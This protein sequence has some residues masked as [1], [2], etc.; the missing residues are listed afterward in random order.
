MKFSDIKF[1][2]I[3]LS[4]RITF[5]ALLLVVAGGLLWMNKDLENDREVYLSERSADLKMDIHLEQVRLTQSIDSLRQDVLFLA[6]LPSVSGIVRA[7]ANNGIDPRDKSTYAEWEVRL[8]EILA[9]FLRAHPE[10]YQASYIGAAGEGRELVQVENRDGH[11]VVAPHDALQ[12]RGDRDYFKAGLMLTAGRVYLSD[13]APDLEQGGTQELHRPALHAVTTVFDASGRVFGMVVINKDVHS[14]FASISEGLPSAVQSYMADQ[15]GH[16]LFHADAKS[17]EPGGKDN[18]AGDFPAL[19]PMFEPQTKHNDP[20]FQTV[21]DGNG[22]YLAAERVYFDVSDPS[23]FLLLACHLPANAAVQG[24]KEIS[25]PDLV[26]TMLVMLLVGVVFMLVL[27]RTFSPLNRITVAAHEIAAGN[28][29]VR[30]EETGKGEIRKLAKALNTMLDKLSDSDQ[31]KQE[32]VFRKELIEALPGVFYMIDAQGRFLLWNHNLERVLQLGPEEMAASHPLDF[33]GGEDKSNIE[34]TIRQVFA[35]GDGEVEAELVSKDGT[36]T[37]YHLNGRRVER[38]GAPVLVGL[39]LDITRQ[40]ESL[41]E[42][43]TQLRR[44]QTLMRNSMEGIH[45]LDI[46]GNVLEANDAFCSMLG[47]TR[48]EILQLNVRDWDVHYPAEEL[49]ARISSFIGRSDMFDTMHRRKDG[50]VIDVE[51]CVNGV[52][53]DD[54][55][56]LFASSRDITER[57]KLQIA[58]QRYKQ[59]IDAAMDGYWMV[60]TDGIL[61]EVNEAYANM[62]GYTMRELVG[63]HIS[64]LDANEN[65]AEV[66]VH[67]DRLMAQGYGRFESQHRRKDGRVFDVEVS[68]TFLPEA[69]KFFVFSHNITLRKQAEQALRVAAATFEMHEAILITDAQASIVR[70]N[71][72]FTDITGYSSEDVIGKNPRIMSSGRHDK[73]F[74]AALW[75][76][77]LDTGSWAGEIWDRRKNGEI[78]PK[79]MTITAVKNQRGETTQYVAIFSDITERKRAE[80]EIRNLAFYDALT[81]LANRRLFIERFQTA[82][83]TSVRYG[84]HGA[85]LFVDL[86]RFKHLND[87]L[88]HDYGDLLLIEVAA[89]IKSCVREVDTVARFG[90]DEFVV[91]LENI[92][93][94]GLDASHKAGGVAEKIREALS[95]PYHLNGQECHSSPSIGISLYHGNEESMDAL[96]RQADAAMYQAKE[97]GRNNVRFY[98][99]Q[100]QQNWETQPLTVPD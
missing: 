42:A 12:A 54:K 52:V 56:Y 1:S 45:V 62:S 27:R 87:T 2:D 22:G 64:Q 57:K 66:R 40:R 70:V 34:R 79:W 31:I 30:L 6:S 75:G 7:S 84:G 58:Q 32:S 13:F 4:A 18:V 17:S 61:E 67:T 36:R 78:Y 53:I 99:A 83:A 19:K 24:F 95:Q 15:Y 76:Q 65:E 100:M 97:A 51:I 86:D 96:I 35:K 74:Y 41:R 21:S 90:G 89:R 20:S 28:R 63:M 93:G 50:S 26:D 77:I 82:L 14:L 60:N 8:Q 72:A 38:D 94:D 43:K 47:Y 11:V 69:G 46:D 49:R 3:G 33:F 73:A 5:W 23:R 68:V 88:G 81:Q 9:A 59:V 10:Y 29:S 25:Q 71:S 92:S 80:E 91:L 37:P 48:E 16:Y 85:I 44:N 39:G 55:A 98:D